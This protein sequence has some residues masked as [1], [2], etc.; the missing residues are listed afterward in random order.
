MKDTHLLFS[1]NIVKVNPVPLPPAI[2]I[3]LKDKSEDNNTIIYG[4]IKT[5]SNWISITDTKTDEFNALKQYLNPPSYTATFPI[6]GE[7]LREIFCTN[8]DKCKSP[9]LDRCNEIAN[10]IN[11]YSDKFEINTALKLSYFLGQIGTETQRL[12]KLQETTCYKS[13]DRIKEIFGKIYYCDLFEGYEASWDEC[14]EGHPKQ[15]TPKLAKI[16]SD[17]VVK[18]KYVCSPLLIDYTYSCR[19]GNGTPASGDGSKF[20]GKGFIHLTGKGQFENISNLWNADPDN[21]NNKK[22]FAGKDINEIT[23]NIDVAMRASMYYWKD[24]ELNTLVKPDM[25]DSQIDK[26][27]AI[28]NGTNPPNSPDDRR[29]FTKKAYSILIK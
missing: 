3:S 4:S 19:M 24:N 6:T 5:S 13:K 27:G 16:T 22:D 18:D 26:V 20:L 29:K 17:L 25:K 1:D 12:N 15:C 21:V 23:D 8:V 11:K 14:G 2:D 7:Q 9:S 10:V 28:V